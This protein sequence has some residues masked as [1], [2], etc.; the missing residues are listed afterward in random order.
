MLYAITACRWGDDNRPAAVMLARVV[1]PGLH[2]EYDT[3]RETDAQQ[4]VALIRGGDRMQAL[5]G[6]RLGPFV[7]TLVRPDGT[8]TLQDI[9]NVHAGQSLE[10]LPTF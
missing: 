3:A 6:T 7:R 4:A 5:F 9:P 1:S 10:D 8:E 2:P